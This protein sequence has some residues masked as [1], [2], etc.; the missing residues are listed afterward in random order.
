MPAFEP[1]ATITSILPSAFT[2]AATMLAAVPFPATA[3]ELGGEIVVVRR[4]P[5]C[6]ARNQLPRVDYSNSRL[7]YIGFEIWIQLPVARV[8]QLGN[9]RI[10]T[11]TA[12][13]ED[14]RRLAPLAA[15][16]VP[17]AHPHQNADAFQNNLPIRGIW[18]RG[19]QKRQECRHLDR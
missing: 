11:R 16:N 10:E 9:L 13:G 19:I 5:Q 6:L 14:E 17:A 15:E 3:C 2:P 12:A 7:S 8:V 4:T 18:R 1:F